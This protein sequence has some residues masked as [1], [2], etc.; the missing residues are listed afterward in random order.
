MIPGSLR[1]GILVL[2]LLLAAPAFAKEAVDVELVLAIDIS[3]S[4]DPDEARMQREGYVAAL[5][6]RR[7]LGAITSGIHGKIAIAYVEWASSYQRNTLLDW[8]VIDGAG[9]AGAT[10]AKLA[11]IPINIGQRTSISTAIDYSMQMLGKSP[12]EGIRR[13]IDISGDGP[14]N[15]GGLV[16]TARDRALDAGVI[17]NGLPIINGKPNRFGFPTMQDLDRYYEGCVI[18][19][20]GSFVVKADSF[21]AFADAVKQKLILE[22]AGLTPPRTQYAALDGP[23]LDSVGQL[24]QQKPEYHLGCDIGERQSRDYFRQRWER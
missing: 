19:G 1:R 24:A 11:A 3:G 4:I 5:T 2:A 6:D 7:V 15:D 21:E 10:A 23:P 9:S 16:T 22:I 12:F 14:N 20:P 17:I 8:T 18:G 13:V